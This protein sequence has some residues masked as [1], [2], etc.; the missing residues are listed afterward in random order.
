MGC[1]HTAAF[2]RPSSS[3]LAGGA[4]VKQSGSKWLTVA[5]T[6]PEGTVIVAGL[7]GYRAGLASKRLRSATYA[8]SLAN[9]VLIT[10]NDQPIMP[11]T[12]SQLS[13]VLRNNSRQI[14]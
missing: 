9:M 12:A 10:G 7:G 3:W 1:K 4:L 13:S 8:I 5:I 6:S 14:F 2:Q 11:Y